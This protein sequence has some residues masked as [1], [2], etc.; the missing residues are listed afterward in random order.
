LRGCVGRRALLER[1]TALFAIHVRCMSKLDPRSA[2]PVDV[3]V[4]SDRRNRARAFS[5][6]V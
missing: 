3:A 5:G 2:L 6:V 4:F 1:G